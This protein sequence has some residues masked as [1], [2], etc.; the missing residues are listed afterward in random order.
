MSRCKYFGLCGAP[1][2]GGLLGNRPGNG[3]RSCPGR[4]GTLGSGE[5]V[6]E[7]RLA[8]LRELKRGAS[9]RLGRAEGQDE[10]SSIVAG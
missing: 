9:L 7:L 5:R 4:R 8:I 3:W 6:L 1:W 10:A 2:S